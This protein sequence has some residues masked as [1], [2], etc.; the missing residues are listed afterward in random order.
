MAIRDGDA[1]ALSAPK[2]IAGRI[3]GDSPGGVASVEARRFT[4]NMKAYELYLKG[5]LCWARSGECAT[6]IASAERNRR[7]SRS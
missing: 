5:K 1:L 4:E 7:S 3:G 2:A 6:A